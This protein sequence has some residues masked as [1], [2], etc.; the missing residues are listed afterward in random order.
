MYYYGGY[1]GY[2]NG[3]CGGYSGGGYGYGSGYEYRAENEVLCKSGLSHLKV[4]NLVNYYFVCDTL[5]TEPV[6]ENGSVK[7]AGKW[8]DGTV[9]GIGNDP[10][11]KRKTDYAGA[12]KDYYAYSKLKSKLF[13]D[14]LSDYQG[15]DLEKINSDEDS[16]FLSG[17][18][19]EKYF[20]YK[21]A[22]ALQAAGIIDSE[23][24][25]VDSKKCE[26]E[27]MIKYRNSSSFMKL[28]AIIIAI[29]ALLF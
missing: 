27:F 17:K 5:E 4:E 24:K 29:F 19:Y 22:P 10:F 26:Y 12:N 1:Q 15:L 18:I 2:G 13:E 16:G 14:F 11:C 8:S 28:K 20:L 9:I 6:C 25:V 21:N 3:C 23:G 7:T